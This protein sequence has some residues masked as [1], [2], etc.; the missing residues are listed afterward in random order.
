M[1]A[2][3]AAAAGLARRVRPLPVD[4]SELAVF[5][6][7]LP[8][9]R[10]RLFAVDVGDP[11]VLCRAALAAAR[12]YDRWPAV[13]HAWD[14]AIAPVLA[15]A[16]GVLDRPLA[17]RVAS[18][19][20]LAGDPAAIRVAIAAADRVILPSPRA[21]DAFGRREIAGELAAAFAAA[22]GKLRGIR[23]GIDTTQWDP[24]RD[25]TLPAR[26]DARDPTGKARCKE[27]LQ[28]ECGLRRR[29]RTPLLAC[30]APRGAAADRLREAL[31]AIA[32]IPVQVVVR[33]PPGH[34]AASAL[35]ARADALA[36]RVA[37]RC[38]A[39]DAAV[40]R[41]LAGADLC[42]VGAEP[43]DP[44]AVAQLACARYGAIP[45]APNEAGLDD[46]LVDFDPNTQTGTGFCFDGTDPG[47]LVDV[48]R[49]AARA[50]DTP[51]MRALV[52][53]VMRIDL[54]WRSAARRYRDVYDD[55]LTS[56]SAEARAS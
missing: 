23:D 7:A 42:L 19:R 32:A 44:A 29:P 9:G 3:A 47:A 2:A 21:V 40:R 14:V 8:G 18:I 20:G 24:A 50:Y 13:L 11:I 53:R 48:V 27:A 41:T 43:Y 52:E 30:I 26:F 33:L 37:V 31:A 55:L 51:A 25:L 46:V 17:R 36:G 22:A 16:A 45:V 28:I 15:M 4:D 38:D 56:Q 1:P 54:S 39:D 12:A 6:G 34:P 49:R 5:D 35:V 10:G